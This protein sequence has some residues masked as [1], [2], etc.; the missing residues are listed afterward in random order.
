MSKPIL[1]IAI[2]AYNVA[3]YIEQTVSSLVSSKYQNHIEIIIVNDGS[4]DSTAEV[5]EK[6]AK[7]HSCVKIINKTNGGHG[8][9]INA[10]LENAAGKYFRLLDGDDWFDT[11]EFDQFIEKLL[12]ENADLVLTDYFL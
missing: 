3:P 7:K 11:N 10:G 2:P 6:I 12:S 4:S 5:I 9:S 8:S 1:T